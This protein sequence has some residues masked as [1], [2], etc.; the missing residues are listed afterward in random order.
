MLQFPK[1]VITGSVG[2]GKKIVCS[3]ESGSDGVTSSGK[4]EMSLGGVRKQQR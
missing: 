2:V 1:T 3:S 4:T